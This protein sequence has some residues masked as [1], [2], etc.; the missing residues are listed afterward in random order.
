MHFLNVW[1]LF[2]YPWSNFLSE[3]TTHYLYES[4]AHRSV[5]FCVF[6]QCGEYLGFV[7][8]RR[9]VIIYKTR[10]I[11]KFIN[12]GQ[13]N[14][15][16]R[17]VGEHRWRINGQPIDISPVLSIESTA[18]VGVNYIVFG[19]GDIN[20]CRLPHRLAKRCSIVTKFPDKV[21]VIAV[22]KSN[23]YIDVYNLNLLKENYSPTLA[24][25]VLVDGSQPIVHLSMSTNGALCLASTSCQGVVKLWDIWD[26]GNMYAT[27]TSPMFQRSLVN[28]PFVDVAAS[29][30]LVQSA[31]STRVSFSPRNSIN[32]QQL[33]S[34]WA[35]W[36]VLFHLHQLSLR[37]VSTSCSSVFD[38]PPSEQA[39]VPY[40]YEV[41]VTAWH[42]IEKHLFMGDQHGHG[43]VVEAERYYRRLHE[44]RH[45]HMISGAAY[46]RDGALLLTASFDGRCAVWAVPSYTCLH[47]YWSM[48]QLP[49]IG[50]V[51]S[52]GH[53]S[54]ENKCVRMLKVN[55]V[56]DR[57]IDQVAP[58][59]YIA[60]I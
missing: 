50:C 37:V 57:L 12:H 36:V 17:V 56:N 49:G 34:N 26:D 53:L 32:R 18:G 55:G 21:C 42:P 45:H 35:S 52:K 11:L 19:D 31:S 15:V 38:M 9:H 5:T 6:S 54:Y 1:Y 3:I 24:K 40:N 22:A 23:G 28:V 14:G 43:L 58:D 41:S 47:L 27:L 48:A 10:Q 51:P 33:S 25:M 60:Y 44:I 4:S 29:Q 13:V 20:N 30:S 7:E 46:S 39:A 8:D 59:L 2:L 16:G